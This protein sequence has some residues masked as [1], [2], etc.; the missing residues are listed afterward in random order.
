MHEAPG[1]AGVPVLFAGLS[2]GRV[3]ASSGK[4]LRRWGAIA[5]LALPLGLVACQ[6][7][8]SSVKVSYYSIGG[9]SLTGIDREIRRKG[10]R[11]GQ[12]RHAVAVARIKMN[13]KLD[14]ARGPRGCSVVKAKVSVNARV[15]LPAWNGRETA[16][17]RLAK[18]WDNID[19][20]TRLHEGT[21]VAIAF[22]HARRLERDLVALAPAR[23]CRAARQNARIL[24]REALRLHDAQQKNFDR[25]EK[26]RLASG[27]RQQKVSRTANSANDV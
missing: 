4:A 2:E 15:T 3:S 10:P 13:P 12:G 19:R 8:G 23:G 18:A 16:D 21:H 24:I 26:R 14:Y 22:R 17:P 9:S 11:I 1:G 7:T 20:Y 5:A 27:A 6:S 25:N